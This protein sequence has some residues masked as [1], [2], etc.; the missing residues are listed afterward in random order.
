MWK[1]LFH[2]ICRLANFANAH[3][4]A[5]A[6]VDRNKWKK[7]RGSEIEV[8]SFCRGIALIENVNAIQNSSI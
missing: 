2:S 3:G 7:E 8:G 5:F 6:S 1:V 4:H